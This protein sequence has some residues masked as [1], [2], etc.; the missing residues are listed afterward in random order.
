MQYFP[1]L[2]QSYQTFIQELFAATAALAL[3]VLVVCPKW[4]ITVAIVMLLCA[5]EILWGNAIFPKQNFSLAFV[6]AVAVLGALGLSAESKT[7]LGRL[8]P[9]GML[10]VALASCAVFNYDHRDSVQ[11]LK[12]KA[13][14]QFVEAPPFPHIKSRGR[15]LY[16]VKDYAGALPRIH[17]LSGAYYDEQ[18]EVG[19]IFFEGHKNES[20]AREKK[21]FLGAQPTDDEWDRLKWQLRKRRASEY[22]FE[23][24][25][26]I[27]RTRHLCQKGEI[28]HLISDL[29]NLPFAKDD[30][31]TLWY[32]DERIYLYPCENSSK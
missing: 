5:A 6:L 16:S 32:K 31:L 24:D 28:T 3:A 4:R 2:Y 10:V 8:L 12:E 30:S 17:F 25:S 11:K 29:S 7:P 27:A 1:N 19:S 13:M 20:H 15:I 14:N 23:P 26:L 18:Y 22:L 9:C 21:V